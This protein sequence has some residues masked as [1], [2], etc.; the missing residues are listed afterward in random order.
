MTSPDAGPDSGITFER[1]SRTSHSECWTIERDG[2]LAGRVDLHFT[3]SSEVYATLCVTDDID[4]DELQ[5]IIAEVDERLVLTTD[6]YREDF[7]VTVWRGEPAGVYSEDD[8]EEDEADEI[9]SA[10]GN[11]RAPGA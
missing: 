1:E 9:E 8:D 2:E 10:S 4:D 7:I 11:G 5:D 3:A 6:P